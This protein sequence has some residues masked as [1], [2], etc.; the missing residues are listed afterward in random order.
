MDQELTAVVGEIIPRGPAGYATRSTEG[1]RRERAVARARTAVITLEHVESREI[2]RLHA[3]TMPPSPD[4]ANTTAPVCVCVY[5]AICSTISNIPS[6]T[7][8]P[9]LLHKRDKLPFE[10]SRSA[11]CVKS[12]RSN[13]RISLCCCARTCRSGLRPAAISITIID[14]TRQRREEA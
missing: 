12:R 2:H 10:S 14:M 3:H 9:V 4:S 5:Y 13:N 11:G 6:E 1:P 8:P 7:K